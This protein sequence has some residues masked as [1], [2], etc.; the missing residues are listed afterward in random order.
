MCIKIEMWKGFP[1][2]TKKE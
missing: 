2:H 1:V